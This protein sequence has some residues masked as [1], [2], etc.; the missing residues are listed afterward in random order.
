MKLLGAN[1]LICDPYLK[2]K[3]IFKIG[4]GGFK[5]ADIISLHTNGSDKILDEKNMTYIKKIQ[6]Y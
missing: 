5:R 1:I 4:L 2:N 6:Y 3:N